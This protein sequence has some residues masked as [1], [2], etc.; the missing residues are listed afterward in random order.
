MVLRRMICGRVLAYDSAQ[1]GAIAIKKPEQLRS[2]VRASSGSKR[3]FK[4]N[5]PYWNVWC[6]VVQVTEK[7]LPGHG[8]QKWVTRVAR[9]IRLTAEL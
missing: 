1:V 4:K 6:S 2:P 9:D 3:A 8:W 5:G 7:T